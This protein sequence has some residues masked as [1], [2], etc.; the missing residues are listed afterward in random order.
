M[1]TSSGPVPQRPTDRQ[2]SHA[3]L[4]QLADR[5]NQR[6]IPLS[7]QPERQE[8]NQSTLGEKLSAL[9][10]RKHQALRQWT[11][12]AFIVLLLVVSIY[13][14]VALRP[15]SP[16]PAE[17]QSLVAEA[18][19]WKSTPIVI[20]A[21]PEEEESLAE[22]SDLRR[23]RLKIAK[24]AESDNKTTDQEK[25]HSPKSSVADA[26]VARPSKAPQARATGVRSL[27]ASKSS[28]RVTKLP[29]ASSPYPETSYP[30]VD[31]SRIQRRGSQRA[32]AELP[33]R[34]EPYT[35]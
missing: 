10:Q 4:Q 29:S 21:D 9:A 24:S 14:F 3:T 8:S 7:E 6:Q 1:A 30:V 35:R 18:P 22:A 12:T 2:S 25:I 32:V 20:T 34:I 27:A 5:G 11:S 16:Q 33:G 31:L 23:P 28:P 17:P 15:T 13:S 19:L 26:K